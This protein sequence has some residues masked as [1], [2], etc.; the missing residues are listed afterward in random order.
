[1]SDTRK[2]LYASGYW[3]ARQE[4]LWDKLEKKEEKL[5]QRLHKSYDESFALIEKDIAAFYG[6]FAKEDVV[7]YRTLL[8]NLSDV[9]KKLLFRHMDDFALK[10]P[11]HAD[12]LPLRQNIYKLDRLQG[13]QASIKMA[14]LELGAKEEKLLGKHFE[15]V[16]RDGYEGISKA[17][18]FS[19]SFYKFDKE[20]ANLFLSQAWGDDK[21]YSDRIWENKEK[22]YDHVKTKLKEGFI[23][24]DSYDR[25]IKNMRQAFVGTSTANIKR[26]IRT[27][28]TF[29]NNQA[30]MKP[31]EQAGAE[32]YVFRAVMDERTSAVCISLHGE[33]FYITDRSA[34]TNFPPM[35]PNCRSTFE[36]VIPDKWRL[37]EPTVEDLAKELEE[38]GK[39]N[40]GSKL[41]VGHRL[42]YSL[43]YV[44]TLSSGKQVYMTNHAAAHSFHKHVLSDKAFPVKIFSKMPEILENY[45]ATARNQKVVKGKLFF[46]SAQSLGLVGRK[47][48]IELATEE[49]DDVLVIHLSYLGKGKKG[50]KIGLTKK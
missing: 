13:L 50:K 29:V 18:D 42:K 15:E 44:T 35:H 26:L 17:F 25:M 47:G 39:E 2:D 11:E 31:F 22:L 27:E 23:R 7:R 45:D 19:K 12:L 49:K 46:K 38:I 24:G 4:A 20:A 32:K 41:E 3:K 40:I 36:V 34:G 37:K 30:M 6:K 16:Y 28:G 48:D 1:M 5:A 14:M 21:N 33:A 8:Q 9:D 43:Y 10:Y